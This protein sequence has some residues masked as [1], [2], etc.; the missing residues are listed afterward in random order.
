MKRK[1]VIAGTVVLGLF[2]AVILA[3]GLFGPRPDTSGTYMQI[4]VSSDG[5]VGY[6]PSER[7]QSMTVIASRSAV[8]NAPEPGK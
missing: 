5:Q 8:S 6:R 2:V 4:M 1:L 7:M 3:T